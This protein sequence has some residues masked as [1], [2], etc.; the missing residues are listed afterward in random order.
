MTDSAS[1]VGTFAINIELDGAQHSF[2]CRSDQTVLDAS[3]DAGVLLPSS[4]G[5]GMCTNCAA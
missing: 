3:E 5:A 2:A 1:A 4:C